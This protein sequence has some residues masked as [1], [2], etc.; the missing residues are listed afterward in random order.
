MLRSRKGRSGPGVGEGGKSR[1]VHGAHG[2]ACRFTTASGAGDSHRPQSLP[3]M[4]TAGGLSKRCNV[5]MCLSAATAAAPVHAPRPVPPRCCHAGLGAARHHRFSVDQRARQRPR[6]RP[7]PR[8]RGSRRQRWQRHGW[9]GRSGPG[10]RGRG[11]GLRAQGSARGSGQV[12]G[13]F[14]GFRVQA[15]TTSSSG[16][17]PGQALQVPSLCG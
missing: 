11:S 17:K 5:S 9:V 13:F 8:R 4:R 1:A 12:R 6:W 14:V 10:L 3:S 7:Q 16:N 15:A 2:D